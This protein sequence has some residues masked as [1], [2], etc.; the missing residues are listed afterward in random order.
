MN[1]KKVNTQ[2]LGYLRMLNKLDA[3]MDNVKG[4]LNPNVCQTYAYKTKTI[5]PQSSI[6][7]D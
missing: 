2:L 7:N 5:L 6:Y 3:D 4:A 1:E